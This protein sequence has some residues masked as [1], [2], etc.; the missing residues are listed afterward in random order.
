MIRYERFFKN[1]EKVI[2]YELTTFQRVGSKKKE[3]EGYMPLSIELLEHQNEVDSEPHTCISLCHYG[4]QNGDLMRDPE[5]L[6]RINFAE[7][8]AIPCYYRNDYMGIEQEI[9]YG[10]RSKGLDSF[11]DT[12]FSNLKA[13]GFYGNL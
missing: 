7:R 1:L 12:W 2:G 13:Q 9:P 10:N 6:F 3:V 5:I 4:E 8:T 11:C